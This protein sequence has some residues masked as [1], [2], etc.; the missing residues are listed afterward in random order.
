MSN[1]QVWY[2]IIASSILIFA[3]IVEI[4]GNGK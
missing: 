3:A 1:A 2:V 4:G